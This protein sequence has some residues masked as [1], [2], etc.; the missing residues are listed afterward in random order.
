[1]RLFRGMSKLQY[2]ARTGLTP[3][4]DVAEGQLYAG[5]LSV[6][7]RDPA[8]VALY[9]IGAGDS[10]VSTGPCL[11]NSLYLHATHSDFYPHA[12][13]SFSTSFHVAAYFSYVHNRH[14]DDLGIVIETDCRVLEEAGIPWHRNHDVHPWES[15]VS[16]LVANAAQLPDHVV[17]NV[18]EIYLGG[19]HASALALDLEHTGKQGVP[20]FLRNVDHPFCQ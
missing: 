7:G 1:M 6:L 2:A 16:V 13:L 12:L 8:E 9:E 3:R 15:E 10:N 14:I 20:P 4:S 18:H 17:T 11:G 5:G 19:L